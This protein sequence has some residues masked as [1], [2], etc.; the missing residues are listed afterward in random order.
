MNIVELLIEKN[1]Q[2]LD[3]GFYGACN[4][5]YINIVKLIIERENNN[6]SWD[7]GL[8]EACGKHLD[9][10]KLMIEKGAGDCIQHEFNIRECF[11]VLDL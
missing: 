5:G 2:N 7:F 4:G 11:H 1:T 3:Q 6:Y 9:I 10:V 8:S